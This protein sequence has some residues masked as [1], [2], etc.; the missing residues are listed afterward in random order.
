MQHH[1]A[2]KLLAL[3]SAAFPHRDLPEETRALYVDELV[4]LDC[5]RCG[6]TSTR[7]LIR[8]ARF[9]PPISDVLAE[10]RTEHASAHRDERSALPD[11]EWTEADEAASEAAMRKAFA[12]YRSRAGAEADPSPEIMKPRAP[13]ESPEQI[14]ARRAAMRERFEEFYGAEIEAGR[15][16]RAQLGEVG[17]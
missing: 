10:Y 3:L 17:L 6:Y 12:E 7:T 4:S 16:V 11:H 2:R 5:A 13:S 14:E 1:E 9:F 15:R 8:E